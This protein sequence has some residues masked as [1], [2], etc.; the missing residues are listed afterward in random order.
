[1]ITFWFVK[2]GSEGKAGSGSGLAGK[3]AGA[4]RELSWKAG[5]VWSMPVS[6][7]AI[8]MPL[9]ELE[10]PPSALQAA[11]PNANAYGVALGPPVL[12]AEGGTAWRSMNDRAG[13]LLLGLTPLLSPIEGAPG[14][15]LVA[16]PLLTEADAQALC[17]GFAKLGI[18]C[19]TVPFMGAAVVSN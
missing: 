6:R 10:S 5:C 12:E 9:P 19:S 3:L 15:R 7:I 13:T 2:F 16:G 8:L 18:A 17:G 1:M 11:A 4:G 14:R